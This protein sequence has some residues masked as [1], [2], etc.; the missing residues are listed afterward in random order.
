MSIPPP[1][2]ASLI[3]LPWIVRLRYGLAA[4]IAVL[5][6]AVQ[7]LLGIDVP[8]VPMLVFPAVIVAS[9]VFLSHLSLAPAGVSKLPKA[10]LVGLAFVLDIGCLTGLLALSG[11]PSNPFSLLYLVH[12]TLAATILTKR[13]TW[14]LGFLATFCFGLLFFAHRQVPAFG[15]HHQ[16]SGPSLHLI[17]MWVAFAVASFLVALFSGKI[18]ELIRD[19]EESLRS[20]QLELA[21]KDRL[22]SLVT[23]AAG[24]AH[25]L[26]TPLGTIAIVAK[27]LEIYATEHKQDRLIA[28]DCRLMRAEVDRCQAILANMSV[29]GAEPV[30]EVPDW[31]TPALLLADLDH[32]LAAAGRLQISIETDAAG[33]TLHLPPR[34][35]RQAVVALVKNGLE[36]SSPEGLVR[37]RV[38]RGVENVLIEIT[39]QGHGMTEDQL[40]RVG[41]PFYTTK[42]PGMGMGLGVFLVRALAEQVGA[43]LT[44]HSTPSVG[45]V[46]I[47]ELPLAERGVRTHACT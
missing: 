13:W 32:E 2:T 25:E 33:A 3:A 39:D 6:A 1:E 11:G 46:A 37:L 27:D 18:S 15:V 34:A 42:A 29:Q 19:H 30:G 21:R 36:A 7:F 41:E 26:G 31:T 35:I 45:T 17:G 24:A 5:V 28:E 14:F 38:R 40:R 47:V 16:G 20:M 8:W 22:A 4:A 44:H 43:R 12:I 10:T 23:L 9:N